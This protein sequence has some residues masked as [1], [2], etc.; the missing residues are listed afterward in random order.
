MD[1]R[2]LS[3]VLM[4][5]NEEKR[6]RPTLESLDWADEIVVLDFQSTDRTVDIC[7]REFD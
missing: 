4:T 5:L 2:V 3:A 6:V 1:G 7:G